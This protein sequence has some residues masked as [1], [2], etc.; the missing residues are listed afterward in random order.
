[1][2]DSFSAL[3][4]VSVVKPKNEAQMGIGDQ[5]NRMSGVSAEKNLYAAKNEMGK[6][7]FLKLFMAQ[8]KNQDPLNPV[9]N[10]QFGQQLAMFGQL[11]QQITTN[12]NLEKMVSQQNNGHLAALQMVGKTITADRGM[13]YHEKEKSTAISF[14]LPKD[15]Q[16]LSL[17]VLGAEDK[18]VKSYTL[19]P[20]NQGEVSWKWDGESSDGMPMESGRYKY[21][22]KAKGMDGLDVPINLKVDGRVT[23]VTSS[24]GQVYLVVGEQRIGLSDVEMIKE[25]ETAPATVAGAAGAPIPG[26]ALAPKIETKPTVAQERELE[27]RLNALIPLYSR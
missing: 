10:E 2:T 14:K 17:E 24:Q 26:Q 3:T 13:V 7:A 27:D 6:D 22:V 8:L 20:R 12:K 11:E 15:V 23:G 19:G 9:K 25:A 18:L 5:L 16:E 21:R 4:G 1:M